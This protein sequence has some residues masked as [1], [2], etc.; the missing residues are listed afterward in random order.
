MAPPP[1][2]LS[3]H[4]RK[5]VMLVS[6]SELS[7][8]LLLILVFFNTFGLSQNLV[9]YLP[10][11]PGKLPFKLETGYIGVGE[12]EEVQL[13]Y[14]FVESQSSPEDDP[15]MLWH[16]G[17]P[18][19]NCLSG[20]ADNIGP[21]IVDFAN[22]NGSLPTL[23]LNKYAWTKVVNIIFI[24]QPVG[25]G[26]SYAKTSKA[27]Y[28][29]DTLAAALNYEFLRKW[30]INHPTYIENPLYIGGESYSGIIVPL[31]VNEVYN[32][33]EARNKPLLNMK[34]YVLGHPLTDRY[35]DNNGRIPYCHRMGLL[36]DRL[37]Q[38]AKENCR[39]NYIN[40]D[41]KNVLCLSDLERINQCLA[42]I[43]MDQILEPWCKPSWKAKRDVLSWKNPSHDRENPTNYLQS[44]VAPLTKCRF[45][46]YIHFHRWANKKSVQKALHIREGTITE[47]VRCN[48]TIRDGTSGPDGTMPYIQ[49]VQ[50]TVNHHQDFIRKSCRALI[51]SGD[52]DMIIPHTSTEKWIESL[53]LPIL[54][55]WRP[56]FVDSQI[57]GYATTYRHGDYELTYATVKGAGHIAPRY[58]PKECLAMISRWFEQSSL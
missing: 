40:I 12:N 56:W 17:G 44:I 27:Y 36:S 41:S 26:F 33:I 11:F 18:G 30:L 35:I 16:T 47:W 28:S 6:L 8:K 43:N 5:P 29:S 52:H 58:L 3:L 21:L 1:L 10:G 13:F 25:A 51:S 50:S 34:G 54:S 48:L 55:D 57:A 39:G 20:I 7:L 37:Y 49:N 23:M 42:K 9:E 32:G 53:R 19:C 46:L 22:S 24:D 14:Y 4:C 45:A 15:L 38:S 2:S 31:V